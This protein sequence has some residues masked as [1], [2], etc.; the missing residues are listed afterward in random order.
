MMVLLL[1]GIL[2]VSLS[3]WWLVR[4]ITGSVN[5]DEEQA[6]LAQYSVQRDRLLLELDRV[7]TGKQAG[8]IDI[9]VADKETARLELELAAI[10][11]QLDEIAESSPQST[12]APRHV[13]VVTAGLLVLLLP[14]VAGV[15]YFSLQGEELLWLAGFNKREAE[16]MPMNHPRTENAE[17]ATGQ[18]EGQFPPQVMEMVARLE[19]RLQANPNDGEDWKRLGRSYMVMGRNR[20]AVDAYSRASELLPDDKDVKQAFQE[21]LAIAAGGEASRQTTEMDKTEQPAGNFPPQVMQMVAQL[22]KRLQE[23][24]Q[25]G[26]GWKRLGR[27]YMVLG[28]NGD[29]VSAYSQAA[30]LLPNDADVRQALQQLAAM[31]ASGGSNHPNVDAKENSVAHPPMPAGSLDRI[32]GLEKSVAA[33]PKNAAAWA[34]LAF[35]YENIARAEDAERAWARAHELAPLEIDVLAAY[36]NSVFRNNP[37]DQTGK[38]LALYHKLYKLDPKHPDGLWFMGLAA[39]SEGNIARTREMWNELL[40]VLPTDSEGYASVKEALDGVEHLLNTQK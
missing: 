36:A 35:G 1:L 9:D 26:E 14:L 33:Q 39:Y 38:A 2:F 30:E 25:D 7:E 17:A 4:G 6:R 37:R 19:K 10:L 27:S 3:V 18:S 22:E 23:N 5:E 13:T 40:T 12:A 16:R 28:R 15:A 32:I 8:D 11:K 31:A 21:L 24:P 20:D 29:A 34:E